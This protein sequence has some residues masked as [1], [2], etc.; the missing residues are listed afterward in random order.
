MSELIAYAL[1]AARQLAAAG[2]PLFV[3]P[4]GGTST[5]FALPPSWPT[6]ARPDPAVVDAW[7]PGWALCAVTGHGLDVLD[8]DPRNNN[9]TM[10]S[11]PGGL[12][13]PVFGG[14]LTPSGGLHLFIRSLGVRKVTGLFPAVDLQAGVGGIGHGF[15]F[16]PPTVKIS[17]TTGEPAPYRWGNPL[18]LAAA[19][20]SEP[21][22][23]LAAAVTIR[24]AHRTAHAALPAQSPGGALGEYLDQRAP[25]STVKADAAI[26]KALAELRAHPA[27]AGAGFRLAVQRAGMTLGGYVGAGYLDHGDAVEMLTAAIDDVWG[28]ANDEDLLWIQQGLTDGAKPGRAFAPPY[29]PGAPDDPATQLGAQLIHEPFQFAAPF[30]ADPFAFSGSVVDLADAVLARVSPALRVVWSDVTTGKPA[31]LVRGADHWSYV[32]DGFKWAALKLLDTIPRGLKPE[33]KDR[34]EWSPENWAYANRERL[35]RE[36]TEVTGLAEARVRHRSHPLVITA[37]RLEG[38]REVVWCAGTPWRLGQVID[39][40]P[41]PAGTPHM[42]SVP[43]APADVPTPAW[44]SFVKAMWPEGDVAEWALRVLAV[45]FTG[46][47]DAV[48]PVLHGPTGRGKS[49]FMGR[50]LALLGGYGTAASKALIVPTA[51]NVDVA[52]AHLQGVRM[53]WLDEAP[54]TGKAS[55]EALKD[56]TGGGDIYAAAKYRAPIVFKATHTLVLTMNDA[57]EIHDEAV[58][59]RVR[60]LPCFGDEDELGRTFDALLPAW[61]REAPGILA[62]MLQRAAA[63]LTD[64]RTIGQDRAPATVREITAR[65]AGEQDVIGQWLLERTRP[66]EEGMR[67]GDLY[68]NFREFARGFSEWEKRVPASNVWS[69]R[70][71]R[72]GYA[73]HKRPKN[74]KYRPMTLDMGG[75]VSWATAPQSDTG[76]TGQGDGAEDGGSPAIISE[77]GPIVTSVTTSL[78]TITGS[79]K[80]V[81]GGGK[82]GEVAVTPPSRNTPA[83][84]L[85]A[86]AEQPMPGDMVVCHWCKSDVSLTRALKLRVHKWQAPD[87]R[88][89]KCNGS[90]QVPQGVITMSERRKLLQAQERAAATAAKMTELAGPLLALPAA[91]ARGGTPHSVSPAEAMAIGRAAI[92][93]NGG[94]IALDCETNGEPLWHPGY[95][96][97]TIQLGDWAEAIDLDAGDPAQREIAATLIAEAAELEAYSYT[98]DLVPLARLGIAEYDALLAKCID[99]ATIVKLTD[100]ALTENGDGLKETSKA[101]LGSAATSPA[102]EAARE[103]L[104]AAAGWIW[105]LK[106]DTPRAKNGWAQIDKRCA[107][108]VTYALSDVLDCSALRLKLP[109]PDP[110]VMAREI[111]AERVVAKLPYLGLALDGPGVRAQLAEREPRAAAKLARIQE[112][113]VDNPDSPKQVT[114]RLTQLGAI[115]PKTKAGN[116]SGKGD[117]LEKLQHAPGELGELAATILAWRDDATVLKNM[118]RPWARSTEH[119]D[120]RTYPTIYTLGADTGRMSCVRPNLQ[121]VAREGGLRECILADPG[122]LLV[123]AD[124]SSVEVRVAAYVSGDVNLIRMILG[125]Q[126]CPVC[127][128]GKTCVHHDLHAMIANEAYGPA[129]TKANRYNVKRVVFGRLYGGSAP[130]L[131][132]QTGI[133]PAMVE[134][135]INTLDALAPQLAAW[136]AQVRQAVKNGLREYRTYSGR[137]IH[138]DPRLPHKAPNYI[139]QGTA[140]ELLVDALIRWEQGPYAGGIVLPVHDEIVAMVPAAQAPDATRFLITCM[141]TQLGPVPITVEAD[142]PAEHWQ[143]AA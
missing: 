134:Q 104:G 61:E 102:A 17:K 95:Q 143:S 116:D 91:M 108:M 18:D 51:G 73:V 1:H 131:A 7:R 10:P 136:S 49:K 24:G 118:I 8:L 16:L 60:L 88:D 48:M 59:R 112:L 3:A 86:L 137:V 35:I 78:L 110:A 22:A 117:V 41:L 106:P 140:R 97:Q 45:G 101:V 109:Q 115:L 130:T 84:H 89:P 54:G 99:V 127:L 105:K 12:L 119:G 43:F 36:L 72:E 27:Q 83:L 32:A 62:A 29:E 69:A 100:P 125:A 82:H 63:Y 129:F 19:A 77:K 87:G 31:C 79:S 20:A 103:A 14:T 6:A 64:W 71:D 50:M 93:R 139:I 124:F 23:P 122:Y 126:T 46:D 37:E 141:T 58:A 92:A 40:A 68:A 57:P 21:F 15:V 26:A 90:G 96:V 113:G 44:D 9:G 98:A 25:H 107:V 11:L 121:Q 132:A 33:S 34:S 74:V 142:E 80:K 28:A 47:S 65:I 42:H 138:L 2:I 135:L 111:V 55:V 53:A 56:I 5:G 39:V 52:K 76:V 4:P 81:E 85:S 30:G 13:P 120:G 128:A 133:P 67:S 66:S 75:D 70:L 38:P 114:T 123:A 94:R